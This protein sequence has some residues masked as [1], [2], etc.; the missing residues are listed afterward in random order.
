M[1]SH[2]IYDKSLNCSISLC[3]P[4]IKAAL[5]HIAPE[6]CPKGIFRRKFIINIDMSIR[7]STIGTAVAA[8]GNDKLTL[9]S[10]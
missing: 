2:L 10:H 4:H 3:G 7:K 6:C 5:E 1:C 8:L 9:F